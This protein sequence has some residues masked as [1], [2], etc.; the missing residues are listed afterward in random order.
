MTY[1]G[2]AMGA[3]GGPFT[4]AKSGI[5]WR[6]RWAVFQHPF[7]EVKYASTAWVVALTKRAIPVLL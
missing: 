1:E 2:H 7:Q 3:G 4:P 6:I 5:Q